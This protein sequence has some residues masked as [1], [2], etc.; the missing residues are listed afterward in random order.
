MNPLKAALANACLLL[1]AGRA[2]AGPTSLYLIP[3][4]DIQGFGKGFSYTGAQGAS[5]RGRNAWFNAQEFGIARGVEAGWDS[6]FE[7][8]NVFNFKLS[9]LNAPKSCPRLAVSGGLMNWSGTYN[10]PFLAARYDLSH[11]RLH[12]GYWKTAGANRAF[13][14]AD[15]PINSNWTGMIEHLAG[16]NS[17]TWLST[18]YTIPHTNGLALDF[19]LGIPGARNAGLQHA[20]MLYYSIGG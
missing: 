17:Q 8:S 16:A 15:F 3:I 12:G 6:D 11:C 2:L 1:A 5:M 4:A 7:K 18:F 14:G 13:I 19:A 10:E 9:L 20:V